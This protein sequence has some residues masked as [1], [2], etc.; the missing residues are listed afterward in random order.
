VARE[1]QM[2]NRNSVDRLT[3]DGCKE[4]FSACHY[5]LSPVSAIPWMICLWKN[6]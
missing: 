2:I 1:L 5:P 6:I 3:S 4:A